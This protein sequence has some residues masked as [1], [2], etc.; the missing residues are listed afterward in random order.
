MTKKYTILH[1][2]NN[3]VVLNLTKALIADRNC[4]TFESTSNE[5][6][7]DTFLQKRLPD[8]LIVDL[9]LDND[10]DPTPGI[11]YIKKA[12]K[13]YP[14]LKMVVYTGNTDTEIKRE[15]LSYTAHYELKSS[16][17]V[18]FISKLQSLFKQS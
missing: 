1:M 14:G 8:I 13:Q 17:P 18:M 3:P 11:N 7:T 16:D 4:I 2:D 9:M 10:Y 5:N 12:Y 6:E 15:L